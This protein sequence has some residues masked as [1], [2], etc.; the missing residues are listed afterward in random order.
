MADGVSSFTIR[1]LT[2]EQRTLFLAGRALPYQPFTLEGTQR[3]EFTRY[4]GNP[5]ASVQ[6]LGA[7]EGNTTLTGMWKDR[8]IKP[9][10]ADG[11]PVT[12]EGVAL[13]NG[14][15][16]RDVRSLVDAVEQIRLAGQLVE[17]AWNNI[18]RHGIL[19]RFRQSWV[20]LE[21]L[22]WEM[23]FGWISRGQAEQPVTV[24][25]PPSPEEYAAKLRSLYTRLEDAITE[26]TAFRKVKGFLDTVNQF[27]EEM[28][29]AVEELESV[30][31]SA[32]QLVLTPVEAGRR[33][34]AT[35]NSIIANAQGLKD[36]VAATAVNEIGFVSAEVATLTGSDEMT[37]GTS[38]EVAQ[39][40]RSV[41]NAASSVAW[42]AAERADVFR[43]FI[44]E[45]DLLAVFIARENTDLRNV[46]SA[47]YGTSDN[48][49]RLLQYN[50]FRSSRLI[51][52]DVVLV[53]K[54]LDGD[55]GA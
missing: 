48:W 40:A 27:A 26:S 46:S 28:N 1:E 47:Y 14:Q 7:D 4:P 6:M 37:F 44:N 21:D 8:F 16:V 43:N 41:A 10:T 18:V 51:A 30:A 54:L 39:Y 24:V 55:R 38:L 53:P 22:N 31:V 49:R 36:A 12:P 42:Y 32:T 52:G 29:R 3:A 45:E 23:D 9:T 25:V 11:A 5:V 20:R 13:W 50:G 35:T 33:L 17:V 19:T 34:L 2:G 15:Q